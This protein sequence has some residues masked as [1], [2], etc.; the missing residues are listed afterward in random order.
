[1]EKYILF[2]MTADEIRRKILDPYRSNINNIAAAHPEVI[3]QLIDQYEKDQKIYAKIPVFISINTSNG[4]VN[5]T[6]RYRDLIRFIPLFKQRP[7]L[8]GTSLG[9]SL[10][11]RTQI[12]LTT[13]SYLA[14]DLF[15][16]PN[17]PTM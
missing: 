13:E 11:K 8:I 10:A 15:G 5:T 3:D 9:D 1:M 16:M 12:P 14:S 6:L 4:I 17:I 2:N 7:D